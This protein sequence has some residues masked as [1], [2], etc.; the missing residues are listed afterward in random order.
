VGAPLQCKASQHLGCG[1]FET[2]SYGKQ[3]LCRWRGPARRL[4]G[5]AE[6]AAAAAM[7]ADGGDEGG[8]D[9][10]EAAA[11]RDG[12]GAHLAPQVMSPFLE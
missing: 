1:R 5:P 9:A 2:A 10:A 11:E 6:A 7:D 12:G 8:A 4:P 3:C